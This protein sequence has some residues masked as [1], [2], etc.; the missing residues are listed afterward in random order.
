MTILWFFCYKKS[1][2][3]P[4]VPSFEHLRTKQIASLTCWWCVLLRE[5]FVTV[6]LFQ[7]QG[8]VL[9]HLAFASWEKCSVA[10]FEYSGS[11]IDSFFPYLDPLIYVIL[12]FTIA[13]FYVGASTIVD[14]NEV[15]LGHGYLLQNF[16]IS[17]SQFHAYI[18]LEL[19]NEILHLELSSILLY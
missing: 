5:L 11:V 6:G 10:K 1:V 17:F 19:N 9:R 3:F 4:G 13:N 2:S 15:I 14:E 8:Y 7:L 18:F 12:A 16:S